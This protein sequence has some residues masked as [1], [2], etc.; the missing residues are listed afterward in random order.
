MVAYELSVG[1]VPD[2][3]TLDHLCRVRHCVNPTHLDPCTIGENVGRAPTCPTTIN[4]NKTH[5]VHGHEFTVENVYAY[6][7]KRYCRACRTRVSRQR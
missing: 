5:C 1:P 4:A 2:G 3:L 6:R 7:G